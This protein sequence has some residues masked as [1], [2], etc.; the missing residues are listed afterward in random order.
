MPAS[1]F[2]DT[3]YLGLGTIHHQQSQKFPNAK[4]HAYRFSDTHSAL[5]RFVT[6]HRIF[7]SKSARIHVSR[8]ILPRPWDDSSPKI[9]KIVQA[10]VHA[11]TFS[12]THYLSLETIRHKKTQKSHRQH[13]HT[14]SNEVCLYQN[15]TY[16]YT[17]NLTYIKPT[18]AQVRQIR[19]QRLTYMKRDLHAGNDYGVAAIC[20]LLYVIGLFCERAL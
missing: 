1:T 18:P 11:Y 8:H 9:T 16:T 7:T 19:Q 6:N 13:G 5:G 15:V 3:H 12:D 4:V 20:R 14:C 17:S 10:K 2:S